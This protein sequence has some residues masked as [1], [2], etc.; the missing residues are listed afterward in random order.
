MN[1]CLIYFK[2]SILENKDRIKSLLSD[3]Q[4]YLTV[5]KISSVF[6]RK[7]QGTTSLEEIQEFVI[8][9]STEYEASELLRR[10]NL[11]ESKAQLS[12]HIELLVFNEEV[13]L[14]PSMTLPHPSLFLDP[15]VL[16][17]SAEVWPEYLH[18]VNKTSLR[19]SD[20]ETNIEM[21]E[22]LYQGKFFLDP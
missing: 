1:E 21:F 7:R 8:R 16:H 12:H 5:N 6:K 4:E 11:R 18:P 17:C 10:L 19:K 14:I 20:I 13:K 2:F 15:L 22:F 9:A 3:S